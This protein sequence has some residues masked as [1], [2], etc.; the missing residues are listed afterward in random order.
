MLILSSGRTSVNWMV[1]RKDH[2]D[3]TWRDKKVENKRW[4][5][6]W[7]IMKRCN[8]PEVEV[9]KEER[10]NAAGETFKRMATNFP[11][12]VKDRK[13][14]IQEIVWTPSRI[15]KKTTSWHIKN[16]WKP[17]TKKKKSERQAKEESYIIIRGVIMMLTV[18]FFFLNRNGRYQENGMISSKYWRKM[19]T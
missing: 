13:P 7:I 2:P 10:V 4:R 16:C 19:P 12:L 3:K 11:S 5:I 15:N 14:Q 18:D 9:P 17:K 6:I 1:G 8:T